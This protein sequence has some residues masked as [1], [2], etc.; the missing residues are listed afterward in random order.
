MHGSLRSSALGPPSQISNGP[1]SRAP[2]SGLLRLRVLAPAHLS[3]SRAL[4][5]HFCVSVCLNA[6]KGSPRSP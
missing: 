2:R 6:L 5:S 3:W 4:A 1:A